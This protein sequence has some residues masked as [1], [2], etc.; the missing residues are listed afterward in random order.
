MNKR[1]RF[2]VTNYITRHVPISAIRSILPSR[3]PRSEITVIFPRAGEAAHCGLRLT[4][5]TFRY[6]FRALRA[7]KG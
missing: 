5:E 3:I 6:I 2:E 7:L 1:G 4:G